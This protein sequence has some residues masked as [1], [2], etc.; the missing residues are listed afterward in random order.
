VPVDDPLH[1][2]AH[3]VLLFLPTLVLP[4]PVCSLATVDT[5]P[6]ALFRFICD[7]VLIATV[8]HPPE[9]PASRSASVSQDVLSRF[10]IVS[11]PYLSPPSPTVFCLI[12]SQSPGA[13]FPTHHY[14]FGCFPSFLGISDDLSIPPSSLPRHTLRDFRPKPSCLGNFERR[15]IFNEVRSFFPRAFCVEDSLFPIFSDWSFPFWSPIPLVN[16]ALPL[17]RIRDCFCPRDVVSLTATSP[18]DMSALASAAPP[19]RTSLLGFSVTLTIVIP[20]GTRF[21]M[22]TFF[23][24]LFLGFGSP[25]LPFF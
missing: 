23:E 16:C 6:I 9:Y 5:L 1:G 2:Q 11:E 8:S 15:C 24:A 25:P 10:G 22:V 7:D 13:D 20:A 17:L 4:S 19:P 14:F 12:D 18:H 21:V 3:C